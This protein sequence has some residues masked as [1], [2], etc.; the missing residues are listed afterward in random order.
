MSIICRSGQDLGYL[1]EDFQYFGRHRGEK[2][3]GMQNLEN[4]FSCVSPGLGS[5]NYYTAQ[6]HGPLFN[7]MAI[8]FSKERKFSNIL[9]SGFPG[10]DFLYLSDTVLRFSLHRFIRHFSIVTFC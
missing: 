1:N 3:L 6:D 8:I 4:Y 2:I 5:Q 7:F 9:F 10:G